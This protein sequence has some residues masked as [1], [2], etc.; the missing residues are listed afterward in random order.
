MVAQALA[1]DRLTGRF[2][3]GMND[4][5]TPCCANDSW[6]CMVRLIAVTLLI[7]NTIQITLST[8]KS[9]ELLV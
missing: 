3:G 1:G 7:V 4:G 2:K 6:F 5:F 9:S 8:A